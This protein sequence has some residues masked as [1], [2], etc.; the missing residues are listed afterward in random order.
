M[1]TVSGATN[2][3]SRPWGCIYGDYRII[4]GAVFA[5]NFDNASAI[6]RLDPTSL[7]V[8]VTYGLGYESIGGVLQVDTPPVPEPTSI[9]L[10]GTV[11]VGLGFAI[12]RR[13]SF[14]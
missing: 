2:G 6:A 11:L 9:L 5:L 14:V 1:H 3:L 10:L 7:D 12:K 8:S 13:S 4:N